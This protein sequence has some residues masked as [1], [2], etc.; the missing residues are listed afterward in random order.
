MRTL[1]IAS[2]ITC[3][4]VGSAPAALATDGA[5]PE[6][7]AKLSRGVVNTTTG[8]VGEILAHFFATAGEGRRDT[9]AGAVAD[10]VSALVA[11]AGRGVARTVSGVVDVTT[12]P[13]PFW[14]NRPLIEPEYA[15]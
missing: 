10:L 14:D 5:A 12:F 4:T 1:L 11:G 8:L 7:L 9:A 2:V 6:A 3:L 15:L 13:V